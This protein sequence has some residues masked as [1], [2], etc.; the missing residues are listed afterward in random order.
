M[1]S[2]ASVTYQIT[3]QRAGTF[4]IPALQAGGAKSDPVTLRVTNGA[5]ES[6]ARAGA[7]PAAGA[8][9]NGKRPGRDA[10]E[11]RAGPGHYADPGAGR[12]IWIDRAENSEDGILRG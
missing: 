4:T 8:G 2:S 7:V 6:S 11:C 5:G 12:S 10:A 9:A 1:T 3:P